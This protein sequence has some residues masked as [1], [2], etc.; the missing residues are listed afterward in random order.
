MENGA[1]FIY[2]KGVTSGVPGNYSL[3]LEDGTTIKTG[4]Q[5]MPFLEAL[6]RLRTVAAI[7]PQGIDIYN[8]TRLYI[9]PEGIIDPALLPSLPMRYSLAQAEEG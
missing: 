4:E 8:S 5:D 2:L 7:T 6:T 9:N 3:V 1:A